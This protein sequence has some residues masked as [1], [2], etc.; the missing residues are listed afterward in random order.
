[1]NR[2]EMLKVA[3]EIGFQRALL[4]SGFEKDAGKLTQMLGGLFRTSGPKNVAGGSFKKWQKAQKAMRAAGKGQ[5][6]T[7]QL[8]QGGLPIK[9][10]PMGQ[11][12]LPRKA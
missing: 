9:V 7:E 1:M 12:M 11:R 2:E 8:I 10:R 6:S 4:L 3:Y 5:K